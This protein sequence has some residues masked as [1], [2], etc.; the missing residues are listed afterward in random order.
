MLVG[1]ITM[2]FSYL[3]Q[4]AGKGQNGIW[5][6]QIVIDWKE[7]AE[8]T[9]GF[10][11]NALRRGRG[12]WILETDQGLRLLKEYRGSVNRLEFEEAVLQS[13]DGM[14]TVKADQYVRNSEGEL[15]SSA[16]D[17]SRYIVKQWYADRECDLKDEKELLSAA[18]ALALLHRQF[19]EVKR[20][21]EWNMRSMVSPPLFEA[22]R[23][24]NRELRRARTFIRGKRK[25][26]EFEFCVIRNF[27]C[28]AVQ[29]EEAE[30]GMEQL[31]EKHGEEIMNG[32]AVCHGEPDYHHIL[33]GNGYTAVTEFNQMHLG[34]QM[35]DLYYF[36]R[37]IME[38]HDW[39]ERLGRQIMETYERVLPIT[40][41]ERQVLYYL[42]RY[43]E[44]YWKQINFY[45]N[46]NKAWVPA[47]STEKIKKL[48]AQQKMREKFIRFFS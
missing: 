41:L 48:E 34:V 12:S 26:N 18:R 33:I 27:E 36:L 5:G 8:K 24:H 6:D 2:V 31:Y 7:E 3:V 9:Y 17:G 38:K 40:E 39:N 44:K 47:K 29:A 22:M 11:V 30:Q 23:R 32:Y 19:R 20:Q 21:A 46:A 35:E 14:E 42:F 4:K 43:P 25:K 13:L 15:L 28:F 37:K 16:E 1:I 45:Y 10:Q